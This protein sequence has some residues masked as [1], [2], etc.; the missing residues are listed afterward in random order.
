MVSYPQKFYLCIVDYKMMKK[1]KNKNISSIL[2]FS[3]FLGLG[4][5]VFTPNSSDFD[6]SNK[7]SLVSSNKPDPEEDQSFKL[8][9]VEFI[10]KVMSLLGKFLI[11]PL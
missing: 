3:L 10:Q 8:P 5:L 11:I 4:T 6:S 9:D 1:N 2:L 7:T